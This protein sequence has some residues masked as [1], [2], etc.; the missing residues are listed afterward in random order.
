MPP[1]H[2][3]ISHSRPFS[4][5]PPIPSIIT[6]YHPSTPKKKWGISYFIFHIL[7]QNSPLLITDVFQSRHHYIFRPL[8]LKRFTEN[9]YAGSRRS[10]FSSPLMVFLV[11]YLILPAGGNT[12]LCI[13]C[14]SDLSVDRIHLAY[15]S[16]FTLL[17]RE[18]A[19]V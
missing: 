3:H 13:F 7:E 19:N 17:W 5:P 10:S 9:L 1:S 18:E 8:S 16:L 15:P 12:L 2:Q 6:T 4:P 11:S 14:L